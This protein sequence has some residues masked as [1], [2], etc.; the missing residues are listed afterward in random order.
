M[1]MTAQHTYVHS[2]VCSTNCH[3]QHN[4]HTVHEHIFTEPHHINPLLKPWIPTSECLHA[5]CSVV[6]CCV[7]VCYVQYVAQPAYNLR[8]HILLHS[9]RHTVSLRVFHLI[10]RSTVVKCLHTLDHQHPLHSILYYYTSTHSS[11]RAN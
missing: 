7:L 4:Q 11:V 8:I 9:T 3:Q 10:R 1:G 6:Q 2:E 5:H